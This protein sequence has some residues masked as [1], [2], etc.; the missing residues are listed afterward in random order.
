ML[1]GKF[2]GYA[3]DSGEGWTGDLIIADRHGIENCVASEVHVKKI[4]VQR[5][6]SQEI[7]GSIR[8]SLRSWL[9]KT[10]RSR[11]TS[12]LTPPESREI[13]RGRI[14]STFEGGEE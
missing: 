9:P 8:I 3:L 5:S 1:P 4:Q 2:T 11:R 10:R 14:P 12:N 6:G 13:R 7:A